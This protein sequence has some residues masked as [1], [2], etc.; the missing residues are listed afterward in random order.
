MLFTKK[1]L[2]NWRGEAVRTMARLLLEQDRFV[3]GWFS[4]AEGLCLLKA[5]LGLK[6]GDD[7]VEIGSFMGKSS[8]WFQIGCRASGANLTCVDPFDSS[9]RGEP[10]EIAKFYRD[11][12]PDG[13]RSLF[14]WNLGL[15]F[16]KEERENLSVVQK[17]SK[18]AASEWPK[19]RKIQLLFIDGNHT[20]C[21]DDFAAW[22]PHLTDSAAIV[23][24]DISH[25]GIDVYGEHGPTATY[26]RLT[27]AGWT[28]LEQGDLCRMITRDERAWTKAWNDRSPVE[29]GLPAPMLAVKEVDPR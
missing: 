10:A 8:R 14:E 3:G 7:A 25:A 13:S 18:D 2:G 12:A 28:L 27:S 21:D 5:A 1:S 9:G 4:V 22:A 29:I 15:L 16:T 24:H 17:C 20:E 26:R 23:F 11:V 6:P 19:G